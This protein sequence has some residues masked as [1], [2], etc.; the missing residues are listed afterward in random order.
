MTVTVLMDHRTQPGLQGEHGLSLYLEQA[1]RK[2]L[3][4]AGSSGQFAQNAQAL[5][6]DL[7]EIELAILSHG[8]FDHS[9]GFRR[10]FQE[11]QTAPLYL[12]EEAQSP[13][14]SLSSGSP[15]YVGIHRDIMASSPHRFVLVDKP[16]FDLGD[17]LFLLAQDQNFSTGDPN[18]VV[19]TGWDQFQPDDF[20]H[21]QSLVVAGD[22]GMALFNSC[23][24]GGGEN[25]LANLR[26]NYPQWGNLPLT[27]VGGLHL[28]HVPEPELAQR[29]DSLVEGLLSQG[30]QTLY[31][32]HC[33]GEPAFQLL[34][35][36]LGDRVIPLQVGDR[37]SLD[38]SSSS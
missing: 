31:T 10:F 6:L 16:L 29:V 9:D 13:H 35:Q 1:G 5:G 15:K 18:L 11:N 32:G 19:K 3:L 28:F 37:Y 23:C 21:Q 7:E 17:G 26:Q 2:I 8:H 27:L 20:A 4:D 34:R 24:H 33:T 30:L 36:A 14:F 12:R 25:I 22:Q 38:L